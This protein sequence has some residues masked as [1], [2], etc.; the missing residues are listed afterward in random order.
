MKKLLFGVIVVIIVGTVVV[1]L[2]KHAKEKESDN[3]IEEKTEEVVDDSDEFTI[4]PLSDKDIYFKADTTLP[5]IPLIN[6]M[7]DVANSFAIMRA[8]YCDADQG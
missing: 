7:L 6:D 3:R 2:P 8:A 4:E 5:N 1:A